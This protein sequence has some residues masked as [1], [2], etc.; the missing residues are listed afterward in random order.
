MPGQQLQITAG[1][2]AY[3]SAAS[4]SISINGSGVSV[5]NGQGTYTTTVSGAGEH[6]VNVNV[7]FKDENGKLV[8]KTETVKYVVGTPGGAAVMLDKMNVFYIGVDNPVTISSG[9]GWDKTHVSMT[10]GSLKPAGTPGKFIVRVSAVGKTNININAD[11]KNSSYEF[12]IK[13]IPDPILKVG[14]SSGGRLQSVIF[15]NQQ[16]CRADLENFDFDARFNVVS[17]TVYFSGANFPSVQT[18]TITGGSLAGLS[19]QL[20]KCI[21]GSSVNFDNV[22]VQ[23]PD[24]VVRTIPG[25]GFILY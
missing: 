1:V 23:G 12:R 18:A 9:T 24:G 7:T 17:A 10:S 2:G 21:P 3:S 14:P 5:A 13:R 15:K 6:S 20:S 25:P 4:P 19:S 11:G 8:T 16:F 22:K